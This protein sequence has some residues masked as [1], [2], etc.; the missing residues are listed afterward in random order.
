MS[1]SQTSHS[2]YCKVHR[3]CA[4][5]TSEASAETLV[6]G[7]CHGG[8]GPLAKNMLFLS[9][10]SGRAEGG[11]TIVFSRMLYYIILYYSQWTLCYAGV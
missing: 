10:G 8:D 6:L 1:F 4:R 11:Y 2:A 3:G 9:S 5:Q 7:E